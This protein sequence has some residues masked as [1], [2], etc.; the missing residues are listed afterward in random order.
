MLTNRYSNKLNH[1]P[2][3]PS[4]FLV[5]RWHIKQNWQYTWRSAGHTKPSSVEFNNN[6]FKTDAG[7]VAYNTKAL[8]LSQ[9]RSLLEITLPTAISIFR[10]QFLYLH[11]PRNKFCHFRIGSQQLNTF[12]C[13]FLHR[14]IQSGEV[15]SVIQLLLLERT[16]SPFLIHLKSCMPWHYIFAGVVSNEKA[17]M[18]GH[19]CD[20]KAL[21]QNKLSYSSFMI[22][23]VI[24][25]VL[26]VRFEQRNTCL[27]KHFKI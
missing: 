11:H 18:S 13:R 17:Q 26:H 10:Y 8:R 15:K 1:Q 16:I 22:A 7:D 12:H 25:L 19:L 5:I 9:F 6:W 27:P 4:N 2:L 23:C 14:Q 21:N 3:H 24:T 20:G